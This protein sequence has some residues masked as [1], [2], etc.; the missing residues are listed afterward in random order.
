MMIYMQLC[1]CVVGAHARFVGF[2][3]LLLWLSRDETR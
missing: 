1:I 3:L 2:V